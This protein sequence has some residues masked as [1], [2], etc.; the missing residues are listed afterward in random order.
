[1]VISSNRDWDARE[2]IKDEEPGSDGGGSRDGENRAGAAD[3][4]T[5]SKE[6]VGEG[7]WQLTVGGVP[8]GTCIRRPRRNYE[9]LQQAAMTQLARQSSCTS[10]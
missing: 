7:G 5:I 9:E 4:S 6:L 2:E 1:M 10:E 8:F 3:S